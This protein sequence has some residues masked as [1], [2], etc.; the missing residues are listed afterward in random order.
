MTEIHPTAIVDP[1]AQIGKNVVIGPFSCVGGD[2]V[3][4]DGVESNPM[5]S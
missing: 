2:V 4:G 5:L 3:I 1:S